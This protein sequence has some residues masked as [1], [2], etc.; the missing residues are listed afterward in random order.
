VFRCACNQS[1]C[2]KNAVAQT[3]IRNFTFGSY[4]DI[5]YL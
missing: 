3:I 4:R 2:L 1:F 5:Q